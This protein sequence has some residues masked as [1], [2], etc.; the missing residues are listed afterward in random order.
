MIGISVF[1]F[2]FDNSSYIIKSSLS[3]LSC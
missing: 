3:L 1:V 2:S